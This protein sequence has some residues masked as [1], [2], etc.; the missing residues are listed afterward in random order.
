MFTSWKC[1]CAGRE[2]ALLASLRDSSLFTGSADM[3]ALPQAC[4]TFFQDAFQAAL[5]D[6]TAHHDGSDGD[7]KA[8]AIMTAMDVV[9]STSSLPSDG[10]AVIA[11]L[12]GV[13]TGS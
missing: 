13:V 12:A 5:R 10:A 8:V 2:D 11:W 3:F 1:V 4:A 6:C 7:V 9:C